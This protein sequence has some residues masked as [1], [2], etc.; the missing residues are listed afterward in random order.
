MKRNPSESED[1]HQPGIVEHVC[2]TRDMEKQRFKMTLKGFLV[3]QVPSYILK[4]LATTS[5]MWVIVT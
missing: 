5:E 4:Y 3:V 1:L 2:D